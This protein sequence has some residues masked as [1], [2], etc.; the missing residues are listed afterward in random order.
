MTSPVTPRTATS[1]R[2]RAPAEPRVRWRG[3]LAA[4]WI[5]LWSLRST[6]WVLGLGVLILIALAVQS[7]LDTY[8]NW[9]D[10]GPQE[11]SHYDPMSEALS[12]AGVALLMIGAGTVGALTI[13]GE[14]ASGLIRTTF[15]AVPARSRVVLAK[16]AV[17]AAV[18][19]AVGTTVSFSTFVVSQAILS[20]RGIGISLGEPGVPG[21]LAA[22]AALAPVSALVGMGVGALLRHT[23]LSVVSACGVLVVLPGFFK[24][25]VH[26]WANEL[27]GY[28]PYYGWRS[29]LSQ[30]HPREAAAL[31]SAAE[32]WTGFALWA[33]LSVALTLV[34]VRRRDV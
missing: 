26:Q 32:A 12:G 16:A 5:K 9:P 31:P 1:A 30:L 8:D 11:R 27:F 17:V 21:V 10:F 7:S 4:E 15:T 25:T 20:G 24:P 34:V 18:M 13:V 2:T 29:C 3:L 33:L 14:Y 23:A 22:N 6:R 28:F 19:L